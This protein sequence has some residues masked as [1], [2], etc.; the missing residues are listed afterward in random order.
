MLDAFV[1]AAMLT[2]ALLGTLEH[3]NDTTI[4]LNLWAVNE[5][6]GNLAKGYRSTCLLLIIASW[7]RQYKI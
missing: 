5:L 1:R 7:Q 2:T 4:K 3:Y 6:L